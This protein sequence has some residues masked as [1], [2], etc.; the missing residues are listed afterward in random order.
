MILLTLTTT[1]F[2][3]LS[4]PR[5]IQINP[6]FQPTPPLL[7][8]KSPFPKHFPP[9]PLGLG[10]VGFPGALEAILDKIAVALGGRAAEELFV[11]RITT[12]ASDD[13]DKVG[14]VGGNVGLL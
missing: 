9:A 1:V 11:K 8:S 7:P 2:D 6:N 13:L 12:G 3:F 10:L 14:M 5:V 4:F